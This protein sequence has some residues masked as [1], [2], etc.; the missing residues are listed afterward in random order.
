MK[1]L[2]TRPS[3]PRCSV[4]LTKWGFLPAPLGL[5]QLAGSLLTLDDSGVKVL[6]MEADPQRTVEGVVKEAVSYNPN[7]VGLTVHATAAHGTATEIAMRVKEEKQD[8]LL[9]AGGRHATFVPYEPLRNG[10]DVVALGEGDQKIVDVATALRGGRR[11]DEVPGIHSRAT[12][13]TSRC[14]I[15]CRA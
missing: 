8:A 13:G 12:T 7:I 1:T 6:D 14:W 15:S 4:Y 11:F 10:F 5:L 9:I 3:N 2:L